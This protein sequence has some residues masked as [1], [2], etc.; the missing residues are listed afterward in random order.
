MCFNWTAVVLSCM[1]QP[2]WGIIF[3]SILP[4]GL[5]TSIIDRFDA[6][7]EM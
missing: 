5:R 7:E 6:I 2:L 4:I 3:C 1:I